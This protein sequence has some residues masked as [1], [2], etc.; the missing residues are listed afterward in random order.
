[1]DGQDEIITVISSSD[2]GLYQ[3]KVQNAEGSDL[4][5][6]EMA[7]AHVGW[8]SLFLCSQGGKEYLLRYNPTN[9][10]GYCS[11]RYSLITLAGGKETVVQT[12]AIEFDVQR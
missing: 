12:R 5:Q 8:D 9:F 11:Y 3:L 2:A 10:Q 4:W 1:M 6:T 7:T